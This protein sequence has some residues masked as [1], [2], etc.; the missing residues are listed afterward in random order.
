MHILVVAPFVIIY[1]FLSVYFVIH[2]FRKTEKSWVRRIAII[3]VILLPTWDTLVSFV[4]LK[5]AVVVWP[6][7]EITRQI[8]T[9]SM[10]YEGRGCDTIY[11][12]VVANK[13]GEIVTLPTLGIPYSVA[14]SGAY[15]YTEAKL[16]YEQR[17]GIK[18]L[19]PTPVFYRC[20]A[21]GEYSVGEKRNNV[22]CNKTEDITSEYCTRYSM[23]D[24]LLVHMYETKIYNMHTKE[25]IGINRKVFFSTYGN[26]Y[27][28]PFFNWLGWQRMLYS[29]TPYIYTYS[30]NDSDSLEYKVIKH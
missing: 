25:I 27:N 24:V 16:T 29:S 7:Y 15:S 26:F 28:V 4:V 6:K 18:H 5:V 14:R 2:V 11:Y 22:Q 20:Q 13:D 8:Q 21:S 10:Y 23:I 1:C 9:N 17:K 3:F 30:A 12:V 19:L